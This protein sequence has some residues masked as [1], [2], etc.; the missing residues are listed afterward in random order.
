M[1]YPN[2]ESLFP[3]DQEYHF[4]H[5]LY[6]DVAYEMLPRPQREQY[7]KRMA[8]WLLGQIAGKGEHYPLLAEQFLQAGQFDAALYIYVEAVEENMRLNRLQYSLQLIDQALGIAS[9]LQRQD[10]LPAVSKLWAQRGQALLAVGRFDE[11]SAAS[12]SALMLLEELARDQLVTTRILAERILGLSYISLGRFNDAY[13][14]LTRAHNLL[15]GSATGQIAA[16]LRAFSTL[17][18]HQGRL[19]DSYAYDRRSLNYAEMTGDEHQV[20]ASL[21]TLAAIDLLRGNLGIAWGRYLRTLAVNQNRTHRWYEALDMRYLGIICLEVFDYEQAMDY[22]ERGLHLLEVDQKNDVLLDAQYGLALIYTGQQS[23]GKAL[24]ESTLDRGHRDIYAQMRLHLL[25]IAGLT[26]LQEYVQAREQ[27]LAF[28]QQ[29]TTTNMLMRG[30]ALRFLGYSGLMLGVPDADGSLRTA[31]ELEKTYGGLDL[32]LC[33]EALAQSCTDPAEKQQHYQ[34]A[35]QQLQ[36][37]ADSVSAYPQLR[38]A[39]LQS[40]RVGQIFAAAQL[41]LPS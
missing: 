41:D 9:R 27:S 25:Y 34:A 39:L 7:H 31:L 1:I 23:E 19:E 13:D 32:W 28:I 20:T 6:R 2:D 15:P 33:H 24:L 14:A 36:Q 21:A 22:F 18:L 26:Q 17:L 40:K 37:R 16:V 38:T 5:T 30:K 35:A 11:A 10:A 8:A 3:E 12:Q 4:R 29:Y